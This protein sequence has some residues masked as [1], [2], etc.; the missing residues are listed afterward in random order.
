[1]TEEDRRRVRLHQRNLHQKIVGGPLES[2]SSSTATTST[3]T[4]GDND[5]HQSPTPQQQHENEETTVMDFLAKVRH[6]NNQLFRSVRYTR[7]AVLDA[8]N[9]ELIVQ[10]T[11]HEVDKLRQVSESSLF[12]LCFGVL[13][14]RWVRRLS[15]LVVCALVSPGHRHGSHALRCPWLSAV[16]ASLSLMLRLAGSPL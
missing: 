1:M 10:K 5:E 11:L 4:R 6:E 3:T 7:E 12:L 16:M 2:S 9:G 15:G 14:G 13:L 8:E